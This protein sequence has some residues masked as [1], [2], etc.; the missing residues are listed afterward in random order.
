MWI[1]DAERCRM[2][3]RV[4]AERGIDAV[5]LI[6][7]AGNAVHRAVCELLPDGGS[8]VFV[9]G[10]GH[11]GADGLAAA[12]DSKRKGFDVAVILACTP[13]DLGD[14]PQQFFKR[15]LEAGIDL[16]ALGASEY[17]SALENVGRFD[18]IVDALLGTGLAGE[19]QG[20]T[21]H[22]IEAINRS[23]VPVLS[24]DIPSGI[25]ADT[26]E[27]M[28]ESVWA[29]KTITFGLPKLGLFQGVGA[30]HAGYWDLDTIGLPED[31]LSAPTGV[32]LTSESFVSQCL[33]ERLRAGHKGEHGFV[34]IVAGSQNMPGAAV[35]AARAALR[36]GAGMVAVASIASVLQTVAN[37]LPEAV[38]I[39]LPEQFGAISPEAASTLLKQ[40]GRVDAA[41]F[42][43]GLTSGQSAMNLLGEVWRDW[44]VPCVVDADGLNVA[45]MGI[46]LPA[47]PVVLTP[48]AGEAGRLLQLSSAEVQANRFKAVRQIVDRYGK[49]ALLKGAYSLIASHERPIQVNPT[50]NAGMGT[51]GMGDV[52]SGVLGS[53]LACDLPTHC[54]SACA[55]YWHG[56][57][58]DLRQAEFG[59]PGFTASEV[60]D[61]L[62]LARAKITASCD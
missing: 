31:L 24:V 49:T 62:P 45:A 3:D 25:S 60:A 12:L 40:Q 5:T 56:L 2:I 43:P 51:G 44:E 47:G 11:N 23:G 15:V 4:A 59:E 26:G 9:C 20:P 55:A 33:P 53:L 39:H 21:R 13:C 28:G 57:A 27:E 50:G 34:L 16:T 35:L 42:G 22:A 6:G 18:L 7:R 19:A 38:L 14:A 48:H 1:A 30:E 41:V 52:L 36:A 32:R 37:H 10:K 29:L 8:V 58:G 54:A 46:P 17:D 61:Y